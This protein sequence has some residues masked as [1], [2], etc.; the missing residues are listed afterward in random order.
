MV[1]NDAP[2]DV[3]YM[4]TMTTL[5]KLADQPAEPTDNN[6]LEN[7]VLVTPTYAGLFLWGW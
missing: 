3:S 2:A 4:L 5:E 7:A 6:D 1:F